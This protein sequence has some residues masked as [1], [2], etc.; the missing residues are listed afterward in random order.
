MTTNF[1]RL[2]EI[3]HAAVEG[4]APG[5]WEA[6]L[7][8]ACDGD[9]E[10][11][12]QAAL[13]LEA[14]AAGVSLPVP[15]SPTVGVDVFDAAD[16]EVAGT[17]IGPYKLLQAIGEG[18]MGTVF[19]A[20]QEH[21]VRRRVALKLIRAGHDSRQVVARDGACVRCGSTGPHLQR[22]TSIPA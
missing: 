2:R 21:P 11:R 10:L 20:E 16:A 8:Q 14:H 4:H 17:M 7:D 15:D 22:T 3:F 1:E 9:P 12:R 13:L 19:M 5:E 6:Y 18:G